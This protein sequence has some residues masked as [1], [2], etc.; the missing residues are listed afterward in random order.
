MPNHACLSGN[1][2]DKRSQKKA[3]GPSFHNECVSCNKETNKTKIFLTNK[4]KDQRRMVNISGILQKFSGQ[5]LSLF[6]A[7]ILMSSTPNLQLD[8]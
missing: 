4:L 7:D 2:G 8:V 5:S 1:L 3:I 6:I